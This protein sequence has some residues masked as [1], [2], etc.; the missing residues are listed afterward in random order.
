[1]VHDRPGVW[2][3]ENQKLLRGVYKS[4]PCWK[5]ARLECSP[6]RFLPCPPA[7]S[8][9]HLSNVMLILLTRT[10]GASRLPK[11]ISPGAVTHGSGGPRRLLVVESVLESG[12]V[13]RRCPKKMSTPE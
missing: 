13:L 9:T 8:R 3:G 10:S 7:P 6:K 4:L 1:M 5:V 2:C 12:H 11:P